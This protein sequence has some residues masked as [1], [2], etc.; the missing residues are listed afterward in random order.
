MVSERFLAFR[1]ATG[2]MRPRIK[3]DE[4]VIYD[5]ATDAEIGDDVVIELTDGGH[6]VR[7]LLARLD[8]ALRLKQ[9]SPSSV[10]FLPLRAVKAVYPVI[11]RARPSF[12]DEIEA[13]NGVAA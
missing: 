12:M 13:R 7:E 10:S 1:M 9:H 5:T 2:E 8:D 6:L 3:I 11:A 4:A